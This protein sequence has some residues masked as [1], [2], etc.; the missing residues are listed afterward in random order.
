MF[1]V[2]FEQF[3]NICGIDQAFELELLAAEFLSEA[4]V[5]YAGPAKLIKRPA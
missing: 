1:F 3:N 4:I 5:V 2:R